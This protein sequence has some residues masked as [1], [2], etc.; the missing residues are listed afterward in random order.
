MS[1]T[2]LSSREFNQELGRAKQAAKKGPVFITDRG[3]PTHV[4]LDVAEYRK[5]TKENQGGSLYE[6]LYDARLIDADPHFEFEKIE[7]D[8]K[9]AEFD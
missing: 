9:P 1:V 2:T 6:A 3:R 4:L 5:I 8:F 7:L